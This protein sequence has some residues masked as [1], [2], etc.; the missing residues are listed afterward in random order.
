MSEEL[1]LSTSAWW[2]AQHLLSTFTVLFAMHV[3]AVSYGH[4]G[5]PSAAVWPARLEGE[6]LLVVLVM[7]QGHEEEF[8]WK[9]VVL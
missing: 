4:R 7:V 3:A 6:P 8:E 9:Q 5:K 2:P 1:A